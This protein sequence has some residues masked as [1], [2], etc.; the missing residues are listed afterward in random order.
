MERSRTS[1]RLTC[2]PDRGPQTNRATQALLMAL[3][4]P[5]PAIVF[6]IGVLRVIADDPPRSYLAAVRPC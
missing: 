4:L 3:G 2:K 5:V 6:A 1:S